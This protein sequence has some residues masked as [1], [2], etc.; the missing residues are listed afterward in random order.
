MYL[1][2]SEVGLLIWARQ[3]WDTEAA[4]ARAEDV[5]RIFGSVDACPCGCGKQNDV[6]DKHLAEKLPE[7]KKL[8]F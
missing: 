4:Q 8:P 5:N 6:C 1:T 7:N 2:A 3:K